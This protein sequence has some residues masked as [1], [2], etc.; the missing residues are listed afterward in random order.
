MF[1]I[2]KFHYKPI[3]IIITAAVTKITATA[4]AAAA[5]PLPLQ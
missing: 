4:T 3:F 5:V 1:N 2:F